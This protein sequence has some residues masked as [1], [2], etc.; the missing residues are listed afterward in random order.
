MDLGLRDKTVIVTGGASN[1]GRRI[2]LTFAAEGA[3]VFIADLDPEQAGRVAKEAT[4]GTVHVI[5]TDVTNLESVQEMAA[6]VA[7]ETGGIDSLVNGVGWW[8]EPSFFLDSQ[9]DQWRKLV[10]VNYLGVVHC[11]HAVLPQMVRQGG[12]SV[13]SIASDAALM[14]S[15]SRRFTPE[16]R[17]GSWG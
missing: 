12:G 14:G 13:V 16:P 2:T 10:D 17:P 1:I 7:N 11:L 4:E 5:E 15:S 9:P 8:T 3:K 6:R